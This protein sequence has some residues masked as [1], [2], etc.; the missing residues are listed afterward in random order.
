MVRQQRH[1]LAAMGVDVWIPRNLSCQKK[2][3]YTIWRDQS[4]NI[5]TFEQPQQSDAAIQKK[6]V[7]P[8]SLLKHD[9]QSSQ[10]PKLIAKQVIEQTQPKS[11][12]I[13]SQ[14]IVQSFTATQTDLSFVLEAYRLNHVILLV[15]S[16]QLTPE[17]RQLWQ[18]IQAAISGSYSELAWPLPLESFRDPRGVHVFVQGFI[19]YQLQERSI[20]TLGNIEFFSHSKSLQLASLQEMIDQP[21]LKRR[22]WQLIVTP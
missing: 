21:L 10:K 6:T 18:N 16:S 8:K 20:L 15:E 17:Q 13:Q 3:P 1:I 7:E 9:E 14:Q 11:E 22:L 5:T 2:Q 4:E 19:D 12:P